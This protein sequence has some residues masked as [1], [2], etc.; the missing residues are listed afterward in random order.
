MPA[1]VMAETKPM[2]S[3]AK[4]ARAISGGPSNGTAREAKA[5]TVWTIKVATR[6]LT[7][8]GNLNS[9]F[10]PSA[11]LNRPGFAGG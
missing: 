7:H 9:R 3:G 11:H 1:D 5:L 8:N 4:P 10:H 2:L 6:A